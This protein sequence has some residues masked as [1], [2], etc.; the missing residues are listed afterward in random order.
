MTNKTEPSYNY[1]ALPLAAYACRPDQSK[2]RIYDENE[3]SYLR[4]LGTLMKPAMMGLLFKE[5]SSGI[6]E[7]AL[8]E[9]LKNLKEQWNFML[10]TAIYQKSP[11]LIYKDEDIIK[12]II[13][14]SYDT[15]INQIIIDSKDGLKQLRCHLHN[16][17][18]LYK[19]KIPK[20]KFYHQQECLIFQKGHLE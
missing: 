1:C 3:R 17:Q 19:I 20:L 5:S 2:G 6:R 18:K 11:A 8:I 14:D 9:D 15:N 16:H 4:S 10:K 7:E 13:R 12:K